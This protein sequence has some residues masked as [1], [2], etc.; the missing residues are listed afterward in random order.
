MHEIK[1]FYALILLKLLTSYCM[2]DISMNNIIRVIVP[3]PIILNAIDSV[4]FFL[5]LS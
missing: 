2:A 5:S 3:Q 4:C 1:N